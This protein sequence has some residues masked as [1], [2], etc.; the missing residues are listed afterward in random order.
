MPFRQN[1]PP[2]VPPPP[3]STGDADR[4][5][6][7]E[8][9]RRRWRVGGIIGVVVFLCAAPFAYIAYKE[10][11]ENMAHKARVDAEKLT[12][13]EEHELAAGIA[14]A[15]DAL[16]AR[17]EKWADAMRTGAL[18][19]F[20]PGTRRCPTAPSAPT[21]TAGDSY[22]QY[23]SVDLGYFGDASHTVRDREDPAGND[24][25]VGY[26]RSTLK[27]LEA[28]P[29]KAR[30]DDLKLVRQVLSGTY[31]A[32]KRSIV[33][34]AEDRH[35]ATVVGTGLTLSYAGGTL[36]GRAYQYDHG[37]QAVVCVGDID[38]RN[39][40]TVDIHYMGRG[41]GDESAQRAALEGA[42]KRDLEI[43]TRIALAGA[44]RTVE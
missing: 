23:G 6:A 43:E 1:A 18:T 37:K 41:Y 4:M 20:E 5:L 10:F 25:E 9:R 13:Q 38:V 24:P 35:A 17:Q 33:V 27:R 11:R 19:G 42:L 15:K 12:E 2:P 21:R 32:N 40:S 30:K 26:V 16:G 3:P 14:Q 44:L 36:S 7:G 34:V 29:K 31:F 8:L 22:A 39:S 28:E